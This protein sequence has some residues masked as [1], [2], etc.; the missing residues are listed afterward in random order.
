[1][2]IVLRIAIGLLLTVG[3]RADSFNF[4]FI[5]HDFNLSGTLYGYQLSPGVYQMTGMT[6]TMN[7]GKEPP[8]NEL[9]FLPPGEFDKVNSDDLLFTSEPFVDAS[10]INF[11]TGTEVIYALIHDQVGYALVTC[12]NPACS[13]LTRIPG[14]LEVSSTIPEPPSLLLMATGLT[15]LAMTIKWIALGRS[16]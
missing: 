5:A 11:F 16:A 2:R 9:T 3:A 12:S 13:S 6:G 8:L 14:D 7:P 10:G 4:T 15:L 1:M